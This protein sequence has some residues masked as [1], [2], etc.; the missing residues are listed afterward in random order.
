MSSGD[1][2]VRIAQTFPAGYETLRMDFN[3]AVSQ[4]E[5]LVS[6]MVDG[7]SA[8]QC[9]S[10]SLNCAAIEMSRRTESQAASLEETAA[11]ITELSASVSN[12]TAGANDAAARV[13]K[14]REK[15]VAGK[16]VVQQTISAMAEISESSGKIARITSV[17]D[18]IAFQ[19]NLLA[20]NA[21]VEAARAGEAGRGFTVV[22]SEVRALAQRSSDAAR[23]IAELI[24]TSGQQVESG[25]SLVND[26]GRS[27]DEIETLVASL[28]DLVSGIAESSAQQSIGLSEISTAV[29][30]LDHVTQQNAAMFEETT[31]AVNALQSQAENLDQSSASFKLS[32]VAKGA[33]F[34]A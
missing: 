34:A 15:S 8:I 10:Q 6:S 31:A 14:A 28:D 22:A 3:D 27:L 17:I 5:D 23:E 20:L 19:T 1:L 16:D 12:S 25:V 7:S 32:S 2:S 26:S 24:D 18:G 29:N 4:I 30:R 33:P 21:G 11:A 13:R 9:E